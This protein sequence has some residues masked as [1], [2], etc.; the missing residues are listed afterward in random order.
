MLLEEVAVEIGT[1][2]RSVP[3]ALVGRFLI[4]GNVTVKGFH[5]FKGDMGQTTVLSVVMVEPDDTGSQVGAISQ[6]EFLGV[7][8]LEHL[9]SKTEGGIHIDLVPRTVLQLTALRGRATAEHDTIYGVEV[10][11][12]GIGID[13]ARRH[14]GFDHLLLRSDG[15]LHLLELVSEFRNRAIHKILLYKMIGSDIIRLSFYACR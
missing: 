8:D 4:H 6:T 13:I 2:I 3:A 10:K 11:F 1:E 9:V 14:E 12:D 7:T 15:F 5:G